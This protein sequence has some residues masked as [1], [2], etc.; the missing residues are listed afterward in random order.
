MSNYSYD[1]SNPC[2]NV[3]ISPTS[4]NNPYSTITLKLS[5]FNNKAALSSGMD[6]YMQYHRQLVRYS[7]CTQFSSQL[8]FTTSS[9]K[10]CALQTSMIFQLEITK[11]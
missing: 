4:P 6:R 11:Q 1:R 5:R 2:S 7:T 8:T 9:C 10:L 3:V